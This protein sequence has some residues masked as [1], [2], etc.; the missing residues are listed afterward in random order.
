MTYPSDCT[1]DG[2]V[3]D[4]GGGSY[5][6]MRQTM[7]EMAMWNAHSIIWLEWFITGWRWC[8]CLD[9]DEFTYQGAQ[10]NR[11]QIVCGTP[12]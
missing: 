4:C 2:V 12:T 8:D 10:P 9:S 5:P 1:C 6:A 3:N 7:M 11:L